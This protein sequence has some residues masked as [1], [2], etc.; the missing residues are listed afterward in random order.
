MIKLVTYNPREQISLGSFLS[1]LQ[2]GIIHTNDSASIQ[3]EI[4]DKSK[5]ALCVTNYR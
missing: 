2:V 4:F 5:K 1:N 3:Y